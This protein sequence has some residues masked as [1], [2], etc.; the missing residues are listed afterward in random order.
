MAQQG[1]QHGYGKKPQPCRLCSTG[2]AAG[3]PYCASCR[4]CVDAEE[5]RKAAARDPQGRAPPG[6]GA[7]WLDSAAD[8]VRDAEYG[9]ERIVGDAIQGTADVTAGSARVAVGTTRTA[10]AVPAVATQAAVGTTAAVVGGGVRTV[11]RGEHAFMTPVEKRA[12]L[13]RH[14]AREHRELGVREV[15]EV[16]DDLMNDSAHVVDEILAAAER[17]DA[18]APAAAASPAAQTPAPVAVRASSAPVQAATPLAGARAAAIPD[19]CDCL[20][21]AVKASADAYDARLAGAAATSTTPAASP[22]PNAGDHVPSEVADEYRR[23]WMGGRKQHC[24]PHH[25]RREHATHA[26]HATRHY[27]SGTAE[28]DVDLAL[29][30]AG[31]TYECHV[32]KTNVQSSKC[33]GCDAPV[34]Q[35][36]IDGV[37]ESPS[38]MSQF[39]DGVDDALSNLNVS[40]GL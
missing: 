3:G 22:L 1:G 13:R 20:S 30:K 28:S 4:A 26:S 38:A 40:F 10:L 35:V 5:R 9:L 17:F 27:S 29:R 12:A 25:H 2:Y 14:V 23:R 6:A 19:D 24:T 37:L 8:M 21:C 36:H 39:L 11:S 34:P 32:C 33:G 7:G 15:E 16:V 31:F 18:P